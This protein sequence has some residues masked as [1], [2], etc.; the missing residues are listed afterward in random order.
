[1][2][3]CCYVLYS[4][5]PL[6]NFTKVINFKDVLFFNQ[7][8]K[9]LYKMKK[10]LL[11]IGILAFAAVNLESVSNISSDGISLD[12]LINSASAQS[13][14]DTSS[15]ANTHYSTN[16]IDKSGS[17]TDENGV[18]WCWTQKGDACNKKGDNCPDGVVDNF[19]AKKC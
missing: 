1:M 10:I 9:K 14:S 3:S 18:K 16:P 19:N 11:G 4:S 12:Q 7:N 15:N 13:D 5:M 17:Y 8:F 6:L 2:L